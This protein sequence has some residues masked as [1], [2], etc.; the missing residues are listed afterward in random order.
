MG[1]ERSVL[2]LVS[3]RRALFWMLAVEGL[4]SRRRRALE[5]DEDKFVCPVLE[6][7]KAKVFLQSW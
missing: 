7:G 1:I 5:M 2:E 3:G 4:V 6:I